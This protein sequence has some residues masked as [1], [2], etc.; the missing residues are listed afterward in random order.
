MEAGSPSTGL[1][2]VM[3]MNPTSVSSLNSVDFKRNLPEESFFGS[4]GVS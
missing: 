4:L 3:H 2:K 1:S